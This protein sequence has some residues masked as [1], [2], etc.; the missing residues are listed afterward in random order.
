MGIICYTLI[1]IQQKDAR[2]HLESSS[3]ILNTTIDC[4]IYT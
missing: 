3:G 1:V 4:T 2:R